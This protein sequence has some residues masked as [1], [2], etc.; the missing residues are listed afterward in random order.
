MIAIRESS[1]RKIVVSTSILPEL[2]PFFLWFCGFRGSR[3]G[4]PRVGSNRL[5]VGDRVPKTRIPPSMDGGN[6][7]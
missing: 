6:S 2:G 1:F 5:P 4:G 3:H 7:L